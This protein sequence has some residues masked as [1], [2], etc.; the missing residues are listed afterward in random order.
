MHVTRIFLV[1]IICSFLRSGSSQSL[2]DGFNYF[3]NSLST[4]QIKLQVDQIL[5][6]IDS[7]KLAYNFYP[8]TEYHMGL[9]FVND[10]VVSKRWKRF[11]KK[12][13]KVLAKEVGKGNV[14]IHP[15][16]LITNKQP[17]W[18][19]HLSIGPIFK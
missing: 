19:D 2:H 9:Y 11:Q 16:S 3:D 5:K 7:V 1:F 13:S 10:A 12:F 14:I 15:P 17:S 4:K 8:N 18:K 6:T